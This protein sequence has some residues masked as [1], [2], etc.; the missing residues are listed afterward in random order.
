MCV[1]VRERERERER[2]RQRE[3]EREERKKLIMFTDLFPLPF[4]GWE[5]E[6]SAVGQRAVGWLQ[7][8]ATSVLPSLLNTAV[9]HCHFASV[10]HMLNKRCQKTSACPT[11]KRVECC[12]RLLPGAFFT[13]FTVPRCYL[14]K[15]K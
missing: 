7:N 14:Q 8:T 4:W 6:D 9:R 13:V 2:E 11:W 3:G 1:C 5:T 10:L 12:I 15:W